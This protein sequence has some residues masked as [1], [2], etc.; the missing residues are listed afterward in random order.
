MKSTRKST[1]KSTLKSTVLFT[2]LAGTV[3]LCAAQNTG[4][5]NPNSPGPEMGRVLSSTPMVI[6]V[7]VPRRVCTNESVR[8]QSQKSGA[9]ALMGGLAGGA[10]GNAIGNGGGRAA[11]TIIGIFGGAILGDRV[12]GGGQTQY[13][14]VQNCTSQTFYENRTTSYNVVYEYA[15]RQYSVQMPNDPGPFVRLQVTPVGATQYQGAPPLQGTPPP[16]VQPQTSLPG[17]PAYVQ[18]DSAEP[19]PVYSN[20]QVITQQQVVPYT[21]VL[22]A[23]YPAAVYPAVV[24]PAAVYPT[25]VYPPYYARPYYPPVGISLNLGWSGGSYRHG[26]RH[27]YG[28]GYSR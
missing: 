7:G 5:A 24:Y 22:T 16:Y 25:A 3:G 27:S 13:Q 12:E 20:V 8:V 23:T 17:G 15:G 1:L 6:Q 21:P 14:T 28:H 19:A 9:G 2:L 11:A 26:N 10:V 4:Q 18:Q